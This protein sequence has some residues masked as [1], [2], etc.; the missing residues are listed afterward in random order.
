MEDVKKWSEDGYYGV[1]MET[2]TVFAVSAHFK[3]PSAS[4]LYNTDN[5]IK[6]QTV[7][8]Q[9]HTQQKMQR[10]EVKKD[11]YKIALEIVLNNS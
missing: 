2:A 7:G 5:L 1:E 9:T 3:M 4:V 8:D 10:E 11:V 6:G